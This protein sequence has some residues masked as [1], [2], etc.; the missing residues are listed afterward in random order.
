MN[1]QEKFKVLR[2]SLMNNH[3]LSSEEVKQIWIFTE[4]LE[5]IWD[6]VEEEPIDLNELCK[7]VNK[8]KEE[9]VDGREKK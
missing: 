8:A 3:D 4:I 1:G 2:K 7:V 5:S 6:T 9:Y